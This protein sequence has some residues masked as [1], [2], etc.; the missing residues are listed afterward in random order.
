MKLEVKTSAYNPRRYGKPWIARVTFTTD[1]RPQY[2]WGIWLGRPG[3]DGLLVLECQPGDIVAIGQ[4][5]N[6]GGNTS[7]NWYEVL[8]DGARRALPDRAE[9]Y[10]FWAS[11]LECA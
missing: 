8:T 1:A 7:N 4:K 11:R 6:R 3:E 5:D 9:A 2:E 10:H